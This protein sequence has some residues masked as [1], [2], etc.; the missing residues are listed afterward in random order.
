ME[1]IS[2]YEL[3]NK[4]ILQYND[5][6]KFAAKGTFYFFELFELH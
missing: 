3:K 4:K 2:E 1:F 6:N 5:E